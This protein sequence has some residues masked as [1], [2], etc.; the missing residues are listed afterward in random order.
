MRTH[1][2]D[3]QSTVALTR[4]LKADLMPE[5]TVM[6]SESMDEKS[7]R[8]IVESIGAHG[9]VAQAAWLSV[10][11]IRALAEEARSA[12]AQGLFHP[13]QIGGGNARRQAIGV[14]SDQVLWLSETQDAQHAASREALRR[15]EQLRLELN[16]ALMLG[17]FEMEAHFAL[18]PPG[19]FY[20]KHIDRFRDSDTRVLSLVL[21]LN[22]NWQ[23]EDGGQLCI[24]LPEGGVMRVEPIGGTLVAFLSERFV[25]QVLPARRERLSLAGWFKQRPLS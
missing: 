15:F 16:S 3:A 20:A 11:M 23:P 10:A 19:A 2:G 22:E 24:D 8:S 5:T 9:Y 7:V 6:R 12:Y 4:P 13:A 21:Y 18:Y 17:L 1:F 25:H 14:R